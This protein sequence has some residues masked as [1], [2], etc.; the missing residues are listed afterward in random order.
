M[1]LPRRGRS[2]NI[3][4][5]CIVAACSLACLLSA[6]GRSRAAAAERTVLLVAAFDSYGDLKKQLGWLGNQIDNPGLAGMLES[7]LLL[8]TQGRGLS[9]LDVKRPLGAVVTSD[10][11]DIALHGFVPVKDLDKLLASLQSVTG[12]V[13]TDGT[14]RRITLPSGLLL[15]I[16]ERDGWAVIAPVGMPGGAADPG[17]ALAAVAKDY[18]LGVEVFPGRMSAAV[19]KQ[20]E[21]ALEQASAA[22]AAQGQPVDTDALKAGLAGLRQTES[23]SLGLSID[24]E[25]NTVF[26]ENRSVALAGSVSATAFAAA[27]NGT[28]TVATPAAA[29]GKSPAIRGYVAQSVSEAT[30]AQVMEALDQ[31]LPKESADPLTRTIASLLR[32]LLSATLKSGGIDAAV[33]VDTTTSSEQAPL[34]AITAG[35]RVKDGAALE[36]RVKKMFGPQAG[37]PAGV[38]VKFDS[39]KAGP[40][41]LHTIAV[42]LGDSPVAKQLGKSLDLTLAVAD[43]YAFVLVGGDLQQR[44]TAALAASGR[45]DPEAKPIANVQVALNHVLGYAADRGA[46]PQILAAAERADT[47]DSS[48]LQLFVRPIDRGLVT[49][50][51]ADAGVLKA[52]A[53]LSGAPAAPAGPAGVPLPQLPPGFPIPGSVPLPR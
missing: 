48:L 7:V 15:E 24:A 23:L 12:P 49:R 4:H 30:Q 27:G 17:P 31:S 18:T 11:T 26:V 47:A 35:V 50:L 28:L 1:R 36:Q 22:S 14:T 5:G 29:N 6:G 34:P 42:E 39:G 19:R 52:V 46:G 37:L 20:L 16:T 51:S 33:A 45:A 44:I 25:S 53:T 10:G 38:S 2:I 9:G 40:A 3:L 21:S 41:N 13:E 8:A 43:E 32:E